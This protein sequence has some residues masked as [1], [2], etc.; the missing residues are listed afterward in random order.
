M[1]SGANRTIAVSSGFSRG[2]GSQATIRSI[3]QLVEDRHEQHEH[4]AEREHADEEIRRRKAIGEHAADPVADRQAGEHDAD[5]RPP[6]VER[7][8]E[9]R[10][11]HAA[12]DDLDTEQHCAGEEYGDAEGEP[13]PV[14]SLALARHLQEVRG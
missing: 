3:T 7:A 2:P 13:T 4:R 1:L 5:Q 8:A 14:E 12:G 6:H 10:R 9:G 11:E